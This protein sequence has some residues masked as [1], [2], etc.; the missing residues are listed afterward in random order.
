MPQD[1]GRQLAEL[2]NRHGLGQDVRGVQLGL[3][4]LDVHLAL[5][6]HVA[7]VVHLDVHVA[8]ALVGHSA[9][10]P[11]HF[12]LV[13]DTHIARGRDLVAHLQACVGGVDSGMDGV[14]T[15]DELSFPDAGDGAL[16]GR[17]IC[18]DGTGTSLNLILLFGLQNPIWKSK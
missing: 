2:L 5:L 13:V 12:R 16:G 7:H 17:Y 9:M 14:A 10:G 8:R 1:H 4:I 6:L 3:H 15:C 18:I 11:V